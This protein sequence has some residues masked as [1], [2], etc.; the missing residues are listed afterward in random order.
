MIISVNQTLGKV[1]VSII[2]LEG[3][4]DGS[5]YLEVIDKAR[6]IYGTGVRDI[7][8]DLTHVPFMASSGLVALH[9]IALLLRGEQPPDPQYGWNA[10]HN[11]DRDRGN[12]FQKHLK[13]LNP[14]EKI[15][16]TLEITGMKKFFE[17]YTN[18]QT[19]IDSFSNN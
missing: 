10:F 3:D 14:Q 5:N 4:L 2:S 15:E 13:I 12:G 11:L 16:H 6:K 9:S 1:P 8:I 17:I 18:L 7:L 19:A